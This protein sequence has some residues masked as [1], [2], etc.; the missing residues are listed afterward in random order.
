[1]EVLSLIIGMGDFY[2]TVD[3]TS[4]H[5]PKFKS[6]KKVYNE[7]VRVFVSQHDFIAF[8][9]EIFEVFGKDFNFNYKKYQFLKIFYLVSSF[10]YANIDETKKY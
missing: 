5:D 4:K 10:Y 9:N 2:H 1:M 6:L 3:E 8:Y 7:L